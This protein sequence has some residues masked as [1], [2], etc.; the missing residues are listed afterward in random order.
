MEW[1]KTKTSVGTW[2]YLYSPLGVVA[3]VR[4]LADDCIGAVRQADDDY[5]VVTGRV[6]LQSAKVAC[7]T[8][9]KELCRDTIGSIDA[10]HRADE[11]QDVVELSDA[12]LEAYA[13]QHDTTQQL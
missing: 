5:K 9:V 6:D 13:T 8:A 7:E 12:E 1:I 3:K 11:V 2:H 10:M 4:V